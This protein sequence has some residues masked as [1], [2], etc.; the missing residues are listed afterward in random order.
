MGLIKLQKMSNEFLKHE[1]FSFMEIKKKEKIQK[2]IDHKVYEPFESNFKCNWVFHLKMAVDLYI[3][4]PK[5]E[6]L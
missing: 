3:C 4:Y 2:N 1:K 6:H 5:Q